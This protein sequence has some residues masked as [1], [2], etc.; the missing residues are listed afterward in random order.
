[1]GEALFPFGAV[2]SMNR[3]KMNQPNKKNLAGKRMILFDLDGVLSAH[4]I[5]LWLNR[6]A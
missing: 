1:M 6:F 3:M 5:N 2:Y 4:S